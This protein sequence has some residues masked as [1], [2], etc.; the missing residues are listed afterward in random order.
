MNHFDWLRRLVKVFASTSR[1]SRRRRVLMAGAGRHEFL[2]PRQMLTSVEIAA[3]GLIVTGLFVEGEPLPENESLTISPAAITV[4]FSEALSVPSPPSSSLGDWRLSQNGFDVSSL[5]ASVN[6]GVDPATQTFEAVLNFTSALLPGEYVLT[7]LST[8]TSVGGE[9][10]DG[11]FDGVAGGNYVRP[12]DV[13]VPSPAGNEFL[14][15]TTT[16]DTQISPAVA[17]DAEGNYVI[18]WQTAH[19]GNQSGIF[20]QRYLADGTKSGGEFH[21]NTTTDGFQRLPSIA[22]NASGDFVVAWQSDSQEGGH[23][24]GIF[25][26]RY[27]AAGNPLGSEIHVNTETLGD[28]LYPHVALDVAGDFVVTWTTDDLNGSSKIFAQRFSAD[29]LAQG[30]EFSVNTTEGTAANFSQVAMNAAGDFVITWVLNVQGDN[31][32]DIFAQRYDASGVAQ[33]DEFRVNTFTLGLQGTPTIAM[34]ASGDFVIAWTCHEQENNAA[35]DEHDN[36]GIF[37]QRFDANGTPVGSEFHVNTFTN[38]DQNDPSAAMDSHGD[39]VITWASQFQAGNG[40][41]GFGLYGQRYD[42]AGNPQGGEFHIKPENGG[43]QQ[44]PSVA[45]N[46]QGDFVAAW[47]S[48]INDDGGGPQDLGGIYAQRFASVHRTP[49]LTNSTSTV[50][51]VRKHPAINPLSQVAVADQGTPLV[52][53]TLTISMNKIVGS[54]RKLFDQLTL[55]PISNIGTSAG[56]TVANRQLTLQIKLGATATAANVQDFLRD[57]TFS[58]KGAGLK[59]KVRSLQVALSNAFNQS[60]NK[61]QAILVHKR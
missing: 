31:S 10:L 50:D 23:G 12:F 16:F 9:A 54:K 32:P 58:T 39:F 46:A 3:V 24:S 21:V 27:D 1:V 29:G 18:V 45:M 47:F 33:G 59:T 51:F 7:A 14:V 8:L 60:A 41:G 25:A 48:G 19:D 22:M 15:N 44:L 2:E 26:Q 6:Y 61:Q 13:Y 34:D 36:E 49:V 56:P 17:A 30:D 40:G 35:L 11:D 20:G 5:I 55:P 53:G 28:Q 57:M 4:T 43:E 37:A 42:R 38:H 52:G